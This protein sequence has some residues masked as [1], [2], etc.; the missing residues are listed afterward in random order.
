MAEK[1]DP[2]KPD[3]A[4]DVQL[5]PAAPADDVV[6]CEHWFDCEPCCWCGTDVGGEDDCDCPRH[7]AA[8]S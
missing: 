5:C 3:A 6:H 2:V 8:R 7:Q 1:D 4:A